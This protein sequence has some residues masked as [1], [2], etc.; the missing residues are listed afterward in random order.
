MKI[1]VIRFPG[2]NNEYETLKA[3]KSFGIGVTLIEHYQADKIAKVDG[4]WIAG[5]FS[6]GDVLRAGAI[7]SSSEI[8]SMIYKSGKPTL[9]AC[10]GFQILTEGKLLKGA[11]LPNTSTRFICD[12]IHI[13]IPEQMGA[14]SFV[15]EV[16]GEVLRL[17]IAHFEGNIF[18]EDPENLNKNAVAHYSD[19]VG[20]ID[21]SSN[22]N[23]SVLNIAGMS[24]D[25]GTIMGLMPHPERASF[26]HQGSIDGRKIIQGFVDAVKR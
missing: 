4:I 13:K 24:S 11:L 26:K 18:S 2:T 25:N 16:K 9:G 8:A 3:I 21:I 23:G 10:N 19:N 15:E 17:P 14:S 1:G 5:G 6:Y 22:P 20:N 7:A 12:W